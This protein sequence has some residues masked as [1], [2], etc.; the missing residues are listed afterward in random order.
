MRIM[1]VATKRPLDEYLRD[2]DG[3]AVSESREDWQALEKQAPN[4]RIRKSIC[5]ETP[6]PSSTSLSEPSCQARC[7][8]CGFPCWLCSR[9][10]ATRDPVDDVHVKRSSD[11]EEEQRKME[12]ALSFQSE[13]SS[14][15]GSQSSSHKK[16][17]RDALDRSFI[18]V[19]DNRFPLLL[20]ASSIFLESIPQRREPE[21]I[22]PGNRLV[23]SDSEVFV[24]LE[25]AEAD[26]ISTQLAFLDGRRY[27]ELEVRNFLNRTLVLQ[28]RLPAEEDHSILTHRRDNWRPC[29]PGPAPDVR[30]LTA[31]DYSKLTPDTTYMVST[32]AFSG[33]LRESLT[34]SPDL[35]AW[36]ADLYGCC[37]YLT[38]EY[39]S[40]S[41]GGLPVIARNQLA[42]ASAC[43]L[44]QRRQLKEQIGSPSD[45]GDL[46][47]FGVVATAT[48]FEIWEARIVANSQG[49]R[50]YRLAKEGLYGAANVQ[51]FSHWI[52]AIHEWGLGPNREAFTKDLEEL[53]SQ[54]NRAPAVPR[55][56]AP[57]TEG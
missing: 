45:Y 14:T 15:V 25:E 44:L 55:F 38:I 19:R 32:S 40:E 50:L 27:N 8:R 51:R 43:W 1:A 5:L 42:L 36:L 4:G 6:E 17:K 9:S 7:S 2:V 21:D 46:R 13:A 16:R 20:R 29:K 54:R 31:Y 35:L 22:T 41:T 10:A 3:D 12:G 53:K 24:H 37:P 56:S 52:N 33:P 39:K 28:D 57:S 34:T 11:R 18:S 47:H 23:T 49:Y 26:N 30:S 48:T